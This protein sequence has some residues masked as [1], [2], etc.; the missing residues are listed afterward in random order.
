MDLYYPVPQDWQAFERL[1]SSIAEAHYGSGSAQQYGRQGQSQGGIDILVEHGGQ[2][3]GIQCKQYLSGLK[4]GA[5]TAECDNANEY[6]S[7]AESRSPL[8]IFV[9]ATTAPR[10]TGLQDDVRDIN[11][12][13]VY[14]FDVRV[15]FWDD[16]N[17][18]LNRS[19]IAAA[20]YQQ[21]ILRTLLP[22]IIDDHKECLSRAFDRHAFM[23]GFASGEGNDQA[24]LEAM[25]D[26]DAFLSTGV[27]RD[28]T[29]NMLRQTLAASELPESDYRQ[30]VLGLRKQMA[31]VV[32]LT[33]RLLRLSSI[34]LS[35]R[36][37]LQAKVAKAREVAER[38]IA[39]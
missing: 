7:S 16:I 3:I 34:D 27:L 29:G 10:D 5:L 11:A 14:P 15:W 19:V 12:R 22:A 13:N 9:A 28:R 25:E 33:R 21:S 18:V 17:D 35:D 20:R 1:V 2:S 24:F 36:L 23:D 8:D 30:Q 39:A 6:F 4:L 37:D 26:T 38:L 31:A 32:T